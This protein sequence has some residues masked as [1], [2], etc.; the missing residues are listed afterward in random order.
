MLLLLTR[1]LL[2]HKTVIVLQLHLALLILSG[3]L[4]LTPLQLPDSSTESSAK[5]SN[6]SEPSVPS[7][8][9]IYI[10]MFQLKTLTI[11]GKNSEETLRCFLV[12][13]HEVF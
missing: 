2:S 9:K 12:I 8:I 10:Y 4:S 1:M 13:Q 5:P 3:L 7:E 11:N 6:I